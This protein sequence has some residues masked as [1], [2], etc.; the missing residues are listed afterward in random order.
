MRYPFGMNHLSGFEAAVMN[1]WRN[2]H[3][4]A[5]LS[6]WTRRKQTL[7]EMQEESD[8]PSPNCGISPYYQEPPDMT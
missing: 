7:S 8:L 2:I 1:C 6:R 5:I 3:H 4:A